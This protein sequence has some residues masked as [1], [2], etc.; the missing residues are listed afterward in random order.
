MKQPVEA[1]IFDLG[2]VIL[3]LN[4]Q[5]TI[6]AFQQLASKKFDKL[7]DQAQ[8][9]DLFDA[10]ETGA[11]SPAVFRRDLKEILQT[12][13]SDNQLDAAWNAMLLDLPKERIDFLKEIGK[14]YPIFLF[15]N[16]NAIHYNAFRQRILADYGD[17]DLLEKLF[18]KTYY[19]HVVGERKPTAAA[20]KTVLNEQ[21]L[22]PKKTLFI[23]D[24]IQ[25]IEGAK[26]LEIQTIH[27]QNTDVISACGYLMN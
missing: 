20:F 10:I 8:Q 17:A 26:K 11:I 7:Y 24:S 2:G 27:L 25:H 21:Q 13:T 6:N 15:S 14:R 16:T 1:I 9:T 23:D 18:I 22:N 5:R 3:N 19:S 4:Y 12:N